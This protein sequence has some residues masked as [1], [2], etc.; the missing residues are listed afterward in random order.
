VHSGSFPF[1]PGRFD[2]IVAN[3]EAPSLLELAGDLA[4]RTE[5]SGRLLV[6][7]LR[8]SAA[9]PVIQALQSAGLRIAWHDARDGWSLLEL[10]RT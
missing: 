8:R 2:L 4:A 3:L 1:G 9:Q 10:E 6:S 5:P 7:G